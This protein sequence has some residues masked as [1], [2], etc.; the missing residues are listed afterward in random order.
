MLFIILFLHQTTTLRTFSS[1]IRQLFIILFLHQTTTRN[2]D[3]FSSTSCLSS[4]SYIK[5]QLISDAERKNNGC[6]SSCS[7][8]KPQPSTETASLGSV[9]YHLV[10]TSNHNSLFSY[11]FTP[12]VVYHLVP[13][14]NHN[15]IYF[16]LFYFK[17]FIILFLHQTTTKT[18]IELNNLRCLSSCSYIKPQ[19]IDAAALHAARCLSSCSYI[20]P[21]LMLITAASALRCLSSCS[22]IKPQPT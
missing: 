20:K 4:C 5:P 18:F 8:I 2:I 1:I 11:F 22:Y 7:Y 6:L 9:V 13:T 17:L 14:S 10:P 3:Y 21:Q 19:L 12:F 16:V 15:C